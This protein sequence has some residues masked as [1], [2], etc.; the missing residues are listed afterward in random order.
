[1]RSLFEMEAGL[2]RELY[3]YEDKWKLDEW[4]KFFLSVGL[5]WIGKAILLF[6]TS[7]IDEKC[8]AN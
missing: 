5:S 8:F 3:F 1:M 4:K 6:T 7:W 2:T